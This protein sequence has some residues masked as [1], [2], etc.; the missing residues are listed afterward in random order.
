MRENR[1]NLIGITFVIIVI[2]FLL[3]SNISQSICINPCLDE[4]GNIKCNTTEKIS[5]NQT[6]KGIDLLRD[7]GTLAIL[8]GLA[9]LLASP[10]IGYIFYNLMLAIWNSFGGYPKLLEKNL[11]NVESDLLSQLKV[12][13]DNIE[14]RKELK[15][16]HHEIRL[17]HLPNYETWFSY[18]WQRADN[19]LLD[20][21]ER[22]LDI[23]FTNLG[24]VFTIIISVI[25]SIILIQTN[26]FGLATTLTFTMTMNHFVIMVILGIYCCILISGAI[27]TRDE[28]LGMIKLEFGRIFVT[29]RNQNSEK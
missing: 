11:K 12:Q 26:I 13:G 7:Q 21:T 19:S 25:F 10:G 23:Y 22:R 9:G 3:F 20:W 1:F 24:M 27:R 14:R 5:I 2:T 6:S 15:K 28:A 4:C 16:A 8:V 29:K 18:Y 17:R